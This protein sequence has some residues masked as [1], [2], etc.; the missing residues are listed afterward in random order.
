MKKWKEHKFLLGAVFLLS[1]IF[2]IK[3]VFSAYPTL[4]I[5]LYKNG[6][7]A[8]IRTSYDFLIG[9]WLPFPFIIIA[10]ILIFG[11]LIYFMAKQKKIVN[12]LSIGIAWILYTLCG[13]FIFW[14]FNYNVPPVSKLINLTYQKVDSTTLYNELQTVVQ[15]INDFRKTYQDDSLVLE[16]SGDH[17]EKSVR[18]HLSQT[19]HTLGIEIVG[20]PRVRTLRPKGVLMRWKTAGIYI[21]HAF[22]GHIDG[23][24]LEIEHPSTIAHEM[25]HAYGISGEGDCNFIAYL[26]C[27][28]SDDPYFKYSAYLDYSL[29]LLRDV[30]RTDKKKHKEFYQKLHPGYKEDIRSII[31]NGKKYPD[32]LPAVRDLMYDNYLKSQGIQDGIKNYS[33]IIEMVINYKAQ[34]PEFLG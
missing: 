21:P 9:Q 19:F 14:G 10:F 22:E 20:K 1:L 24:L 25:S 2:L 4:A 29:Y 30:Y 16:Y 7:F 6:L 5:D 11:G 17:I 32:I 28:S 13:F 33:R 34:H 27:V 26:A 15:N 8:F 18:K 23:G 12:K 3:S 31:E